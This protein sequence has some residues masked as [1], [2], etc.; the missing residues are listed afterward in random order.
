M[1]APRSPSLFLPTEVRLHEGRQLPS[2]LPRLAAYVTGAG[3]VP[4]PLSRHPAWLTVL[5]QGLQH[6]PYCLEAVTGQQTRGLLPLACMQS[7]LFGRFLVSLPY[8]NY[9]GVL[10]D[11]EEA[12]RLLLSGAAELAD[13]LDVRFLEVRHEQSI[14]H[15]ALNYLTS[16]KVHMRLDLPDTVDKLWAGLTS[17]VRSQIRKGQKGDFTVA[18]GGQELVPDFY[19]VFSRNMR[20]LGTPV[21]GQGLFR[22]VLEQ[23]P[24]RAEICLVRAAGR[25]IGGALLLHGWGISEV[26]SASTLRTFLPTC[27][28]MLMYWHLLER[29]VQ[30]QQQ[31]FDFGRCSPDSNTYRFKKQWGALPQQAVWQYY[32]RQG[33]AGDMRPDNPKYQ[34]LI[35]MWQWLPVSLTRWIGPRIV[36]GIP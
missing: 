15:P 29:A 9:G 30:R 14:P 27:A 4:V 35:R 11:D 8:L 25:P 5:K 33:G 13:R 1:I 24:D 20:D 18:W 28:N 36:R 17:K 32:L 10:A 19:A 12:A 7:F 21:Y 23:F 6:V 26:P 31:V 16:A 3:Q 34:R 2:Q 22:S